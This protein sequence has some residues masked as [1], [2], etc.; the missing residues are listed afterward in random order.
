MANFFGGWVDWLRKLHPINHIDTEYLCVIKSNYLTPKM[1][2]YVFLDYYFI[3]QEHE[4]SD[5]TETEIQN[6]HPRYDFQRESLFYIAQAGPGTPKIDRT[7]CIQANCFYSFSLKWGGCPANMETFTNPCEQEKFPIP[8]NILQPTEVSDPAK[9]KK[10]YLYQWDEQQGVITMP[11]AK[12][13]KKHSQSSTSLTDYGAKT[14]QTKHK[15]TKATKHRRRKKQ[16]HRYRTSS[17]SSES[18]R[19]SSSEKSSD[20]S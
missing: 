19:S 13:I 15:R 20:S 4:Q 3:K 6:W 8:R 14:H 11:T 16:K 1:S 12:R 9:S 7:K 5:L 18:T 10:S 2:W 17:S